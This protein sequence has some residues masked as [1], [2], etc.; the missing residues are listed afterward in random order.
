M[1]MMMIVLYRE[2]LK[3]HELMLVGC[4]SHMYTTTL[5]EAEGEKNGRLGVWGSKT[6]RL[7]KSELNWFSRLSAGPVGQW[8]TVRSF[9]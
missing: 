1:M 5:A 8:R 2:S 7:S 6:P 3:H 4:T 9:R